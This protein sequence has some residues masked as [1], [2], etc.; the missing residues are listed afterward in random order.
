MV[1]LALCHGNDRLGFDG[2]TCDSTTFEALCRSTRSHFTVVSS[3]MQIGG[4]RSG[5]YVGITV[6][7]AF[8]GGHR[9][10]A[11]AAAPILRHVTL[12]TTF[13]R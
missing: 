10:D 1:M 12:L 2:I 13:P 6:S 5:R 9:D 8:D 3:S 4:G 11:V 7:L